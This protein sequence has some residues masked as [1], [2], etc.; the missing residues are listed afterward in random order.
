MKSSLAGNSRAWT[1][2]SA[3][4]SVR[5]DRKHLRGTLLS[6]KLFIIEKKLKSFDA[7]GNSPRVSRSLSR[8]RKNNHGALKSSTRNSESTSRGVISRAFARERGSKSERTTS[9]TSFK[10]SWRRDAKSHLY[11]SIAEIYE[12]VASIPRGGGVGGGGAR[13]F[14]DRFNT[15]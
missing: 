15:C 1:R 10:R 2:L 5:G 12:S 4:S 7:K 13:D 6:S 11:S 14:A 8:R 9:F 3:R